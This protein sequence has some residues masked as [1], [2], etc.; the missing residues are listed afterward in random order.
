[1][2]N[3]RGLQPFRVYG[4]LSD[5]LTFYFFGY[6][7]NIFYRDVSVVLAKTALQETPP[8]DY[9]IA[10]GPGMFEHVV[11]SPCPTL[12]QYATEFSESF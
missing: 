9:L 6:E 7:K 1:M 2:N 11:G 10:M 4:I 12:P 5:G 8:K 3:L